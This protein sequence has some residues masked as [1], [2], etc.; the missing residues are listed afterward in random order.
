MSLLIAFAMAT[1][2]VAIYVYRFKHPKVLQ[3]QMESPY[4][5]QAVKAAEEI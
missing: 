3:H 2:A 1:F 5:N 4:N